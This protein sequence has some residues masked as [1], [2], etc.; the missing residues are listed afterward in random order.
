[1]TICSS[2]R[3]KSLLIMF[4]IILLPVA[5]SSEEPAAKG[6][7]ETPPAKVQAVPGITEARAVKG[8]FKLG[9]ADLT[10]IAEQSSAG[11]VAKAHYEAKADKYKARIETKQKMLEKQKAALEAKIATYTP[12]Q[13]VAKV[14]EYEKKVEEFKKMLQKADGEMKPIQEELLRDVYGKIEK[15]SDEYG[16]A[17]GFSAIVNKR[18]LLY[19]GKDVDVQDVTEALIKHL[20]AK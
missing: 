18:E 7:V 1:M 6:V 16:A 17:N 3:L 14:K 8:Q 2:L 11:R 9:Y 10:K 12:E 13:R 5:A 19:M 4:P 20:D 15:A